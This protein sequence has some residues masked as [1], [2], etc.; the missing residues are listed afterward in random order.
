MKAVRIGRIVAAVALGLVAWPAPAQAPPSPIVLGCVPAGERELPMSRISAARRR[1]I[2]GCILRGMA[3]ELNAQTPVRMGEDSLESVIAADATIHYNYR[4]NV[5]AET[6][7]PA[8]RNQLGARTR[9][10]VCAAPDMR[11]TISM[12]GSFGYNW[13][14]RSG[15]LLHQILVDRC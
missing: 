11:L 4:L 2:V 8:E 12:G 5:T 9:A 10:N 13:F 6:F 1:A 14:D 15:R 7:P 3:R